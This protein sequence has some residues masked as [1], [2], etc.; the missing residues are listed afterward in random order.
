MESTKINK[1]KSAAEIQAAENCSDMAYLEAFSENALYWDRG[2][3]RMVKYKTVKEVCSLTGLTRKHLYYFHHENVVRAVAYANFSVK[4][5]DGY[6]LYDE[7]AVEKL[8]YIAL[9]YRLGLKRNEIRDMMREQ[10]NEANKLLD[11]LL[12]R[13]HKRREQTE[14]YILALE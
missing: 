10:Q 14:Q 9:C 8:Q 12:T 5:N 1:S 11:D 4:D 3:P 13:L 6:K 2:K 7:Q